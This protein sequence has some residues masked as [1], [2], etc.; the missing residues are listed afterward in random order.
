MTAPGRAPSIAWASFDT[1]LG[2]CALAWGEGG[3]TGSQL[4]EADEAALRQTM[5]Q[6]F[7]GLPELLPS[8]EPPAEVRQVIAQ[9]SALLAGELVDLSATR[10]DMRGVPPFEARVNAEALRLGPGQTVT[11][12]EVARRLGEHGAA[13]AVGQAL[14]HNPFAPIVPC[15][16][17]VGA[18]GRMVGFSAPGG[19]QTKQRMLDI[20]FK[21]VG[22][23]G[24]LF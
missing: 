11:Y 18:S 4:P 6:R 10:L 13:R 12:G 1:D 19:V 14:G 5:A 7:P 16:R 2:R 23:Q 15:H 22:G 8:D 17:V 3:V 24:D 9:L 21:A 20:E